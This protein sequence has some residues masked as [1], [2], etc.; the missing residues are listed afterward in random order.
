MRGTLLRWKSEDRRVNVLRCYK[1]SISV[2]SFPA[3]PPFISNPEK[4]PDG[5][6]MRRLPGLPLGI[7][8]VR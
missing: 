8:Q 5:P 3:H 6:M 1:E 2:V 7:F 4:E